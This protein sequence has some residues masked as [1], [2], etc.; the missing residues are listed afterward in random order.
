VIKPILVSAIAALV[1]FE[2]V[3][4]LE[5]RSFDPLMPFRAYWKNVDAIRTW[6][7]TGHERPQF[8][9]GEFSTTGWPHYFFVAWLL[10]VP[11][12][13][14]LLVIAGAVLAVRRR[15]PA[16]IA[17]FGFV[18]LFFAASMLSRINLGLRYVLPVFPF[19]F[20]AAAISL[21]SANKRA[22]TIAAGVL[23][24]LHAGSGVLAY[25]GYI[26]YFNEIIGSHRNADKFLIDSNLDWGQDLHRLK[27]WADANGVDFIRADYF[28][29][30]DL[31]YEFGDRAEAWPA[32]RPEP[33][34]RG[35]FALSRHMYRLRATE[36][37]I[38]YDEYLAGSRAKY[39]TT[40]GGSIL[41]YRV[42]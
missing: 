6:V 39:V 36:A 21:S 34:P 18:L 12:A 22:V 3:Y 1:V 8:L 17:M 26:S 9:L 14:Q 29:G 27:L 32:P 4:L 25:P 10:K 24:T 28:G 42:E 2:A 11:I 15:N 30:G 23:L 35:W 31:R 20:A 37:P 33:L 19:A 38:D 16:V 7:T 5:A 40:V 13:A 41:V